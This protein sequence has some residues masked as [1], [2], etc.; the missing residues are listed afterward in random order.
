LAP[1][2]SMFQILRSLLSVFGSVSRYPAQLA[3]MEFILQ[4]ILGYSDHMI[5]G[6]YLK[7]KDNTPDCPVCLITTYKKGGDYE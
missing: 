6:L 1:L 5:Y 4:V 2:S 7:D 3:S